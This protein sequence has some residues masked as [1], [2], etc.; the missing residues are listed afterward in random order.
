MDAVQA[1]MPD[2]SQR[3]AC[4]LLGW[5]RASLRYVGRGRAR[6]AQ[7]K[8]LLPRLA[9]AAPREGYRRA[10]DAI[11]DLVG[12]IGENTVHRIWKLLKLQVKPRKRKRRIPRCSFSTP[13]TGSMMA[14][15]RS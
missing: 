11:R 3:G 7:L 12:R 9:Q 5:S 15:R 6:D 8:A 14:L 2:L 10:T 4:R 13:K 1:A